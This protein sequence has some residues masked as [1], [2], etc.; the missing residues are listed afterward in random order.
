MTYPAAT[1]LQDIITLAHQQYGIRFQLQPAQLVAFANMV[2]MIAYNQD[3]A[4]FEEWNQ[5]LFFGQDVFGNS[6]VYTSPVESDIG[7]QVQGTVSGLNLGTLINY[8]SQNR[9]HQWIIEPPD[10]GVALSLTAGE[11]LTVTGGTGSMVVAEGQDYKV[12]NG[13][14]R[15]PRLSTGNPPFRKFIGITKVTDKQIYGVP[16]G[17]TLDNPFDYGLD[18]NYFSARKANVPF[19]WD[20]NRKEVTLVTN[21]TL[22]IEQSS[23]GAIAPATVNDSAYRWIYYRNPPVIDDIAD[24]SQVIL[25]EEYRY[26]ILYKGIEMLADTATYGNQGSVRQMIEPLCARFWEDK[27]VQ[28][29]AFGKANDWISHGDSWDIY[30]TGHQGGN[31]HRHGLGGPN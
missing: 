30:G 3:M 25:P 21:D 15:A 10:G 13:P 19:R 11:T 6:A 28:F 2:Q 1:T 24:E 22:E 4:A 5:K 12:S 17:S 26:E 7:L 18:L 31:Y 8:K 9:L 14:Y 20:E 27:G 23:M 29:E 16:A